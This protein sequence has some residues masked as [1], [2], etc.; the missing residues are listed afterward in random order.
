MDRLG[1]GEQM[2]SEPKRRNR[3]AVLLEDIRSDVR[4]VAEG[5][6]TLVRGQEQLRGDIAELHARVGQLEQAVIDGFRDVRTSIAEH[7][8]A[9]GPLR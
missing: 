9:S 3:S 1:L 6:N 8:H 2:V 4:K 7:T 5:H